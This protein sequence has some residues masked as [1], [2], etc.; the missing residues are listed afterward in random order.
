MRPPRT[1]RD[2]AVGFPAQHRLDLL[3]NN[4]SAENSGECVA[5]GRFEFALE[6]VD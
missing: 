4:R 2:A 3:R 1:S 6:A 5:D